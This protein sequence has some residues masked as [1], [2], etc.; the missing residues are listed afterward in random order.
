M[1]AFAGM[2]PMFLRPEVSEIL[3]ANV[4]L[5]EQSDI[6]RARSAG[7]D[8]A[9]SL[10][11]STAD[12]TRLATAI[13]ELSRNALNY[14][15]GGVC[16]ITTSTAGDGRHTIRIVVEDHG[17]GIADVALALRPGFSSGSGLGQGLAAVRR[18]MDEL[19]IDSA[20]GRT[21]VE[22]RMSRGP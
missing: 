7:R 9:R 13:S 10:G 14:G 3:Q 6:L 4:T 19:E 17:P 20:P 18:L 5:K 8:V 11:F 21:A 22:T 1:P 15:L 16:T 12:Q 2:T